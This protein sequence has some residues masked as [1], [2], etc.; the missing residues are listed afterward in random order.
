MTWQPS[1]RQLVMDTQQ[2]LENSVEDDR[3]LLE[4][5]TNLVESC[6]PTWETLVGVPS[7]VGEPLDDLE[8]IEQQFLL[9]DEGSEHE[10]RGGDEQEVEEEM[11][12]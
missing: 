8:E 5:W 3:I 7:L 1:V 9:G 10:V 11:G 4:R 6:V 12:V 2:Y